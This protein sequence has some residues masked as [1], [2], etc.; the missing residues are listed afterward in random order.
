M[1][2][3]TVLR[4]REKEGATKGLLLRGRGSGS[5]ASSAYFENMAEKKAWAF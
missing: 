2:D 4:A 3:M 5:G 1:N